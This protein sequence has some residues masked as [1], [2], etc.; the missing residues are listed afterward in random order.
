MKL[1][2]PHE[3]RIRAFDLTPMID[4]VLQLIIFFMFTSQF[5]E[6]ARTEID[7]PRETGQEAEAEKAS[8]VIDLTGTG[9]ILVEREPMTLEG[10]AFLIESEIR[11]AGDAEMVSVR[12][13]PDRACR[14]AHL[15]RLMNRLAQLGVRRWS[16]GTIDEPVGGGAP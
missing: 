3:D 1:R 5:G 12:V 4:V 7:L 2:R 16:I 9:E 13:R 15:N 6:L 10:V 11:R 14:A 8:L